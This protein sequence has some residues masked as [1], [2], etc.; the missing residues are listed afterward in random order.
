MMMNVEHLG[1]MKMR[2]EKKKCFKA[3]ASLEA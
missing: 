2:E 1:M 3:A